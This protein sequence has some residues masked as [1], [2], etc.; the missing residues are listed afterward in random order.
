VSQPLA[1]DRERGHVALL[2]VDDDDSLSRHG[3]VFGGGERL[4]WLEG[5]QEIPESRVD[6]DRTAC[7]SHRNVKRQKRQ[8]N[9]NRDPLRSSHTHSRQFLPGEVRRGCQKFDRTP[10]RFVRVLTVRPGYHEPQLGGDDDA[11]DG[12]LVSRQGG[13][14]RRHFALADDRL[15]PGVPVPQENRAVRGA[16][17]YV[18]V[19][20]DVTLRSGQARYHAV[21]A[22]DD[23]HDL[24]CF[25]GEHPET[26]V[27]EAASDQ[28]FAVDGGDEAVRA[29]PEVL[30][31]V[32]AEVAA[33]HVILI[34]A[35]VRLS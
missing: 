10:N 19:R 23:L 22:E 3:D 16:R 28:E 27:P 1:V 18:T 15:R 5:P 35:V 11:C 21:V 4:G 25:G 30:A 17:R 9:K 31:E 8:Q 6:Q 14:R 2:V 29:D 24:G 34:G 13:P 26:V 12:L 33:Q 7:Q 32:V 20:R